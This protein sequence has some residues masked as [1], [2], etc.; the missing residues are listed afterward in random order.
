MRSKLLLS[1][2]LNKVSSLL[3]MTIFH[4]VHKICGNLQQKL[5]KIKLYRFKLEASCK[6]R[7]EM[8]CEAVAMVQVRESG[9]WAVMVITEVRKSHQT[10]HIL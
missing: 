6:G 8:G 1:F 10:P 5:K 2:Y 4:M 7:S 3:K 9:Q